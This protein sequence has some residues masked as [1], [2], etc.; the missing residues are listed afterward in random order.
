MPH[1]FVM[2][3]GEWGYPTGQPITYF[4]CRVHGIVVAM[5]RLEIRNKEYELVSDR[6]YCSICFDHFLQK[7][8]DP[9]LPVP[10]EELPNG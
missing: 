1:P 3:F 8:L 4:K 2:P 9:L 7:H 6:R 10:P 5:I